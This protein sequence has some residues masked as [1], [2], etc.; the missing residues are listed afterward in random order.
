MA[1]SHTKE[2]YQIGIICALHI[3]AA[4]MIAML[5]QSHPALPP[6]KDDPN[7]YSFGH[8]GVHNV[9][10]ACLPA[11]VMGNTPVTSVANNMKRS[12]PIKIGLMVGI[13]GG[14]PSKKYDI[15]LGDIVV[16]EPTGA[17]GGV[18]QWDFGKTEQ[19]GE[20]HRSGTLD[21]P[22]VALLNALQS[23]K[24]HDIN[25]GIRIEDALALMA[26]N[27][28]RMVEEFDYEY[29]G[30]EEDQLFQSTYN[31]AG[32]NSC[33]NCDA[34]Q[35]VKRKPRKNTIPKVFYGNIA[36]A[37]QVMKH[38]ATRDRIA[39]KEG[40]ICFEMEAAGLMD[41]FPCLVV[42]GICDYAD[43]HKNKIWQHYAAATAA[44]FVRV[45]LSFVKKQDVIQTLGM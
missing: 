25:Q 38:G 43:S 24:I 31:H 44:A 13:G 20:F 21:K 22:P 15:R 42:R 26:S 30:T 19:G 41:G 8:I 35:V 16:S 37:N 7:D 12:F 45:F 4:A 11:G 39:K 17:H 36:S 18:V 27:N 5:D 32:G 29:Q 40:V 28:P 34:A 23:L 33:E 14:V 1:S 9:I 2:D 3:E 10:I 6:Q